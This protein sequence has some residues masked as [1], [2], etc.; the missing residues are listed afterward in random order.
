[1]RQ[2][3][4]AISENSRFLFAPFSVQLSNRQDVSFR[5]VIASAHI[6]VRQNGVIVQGGSSVVDPF[7]GTAS[8]NNFKLST[9][10]NLESITYDVVSNGVICSSS[11]GLPSLLQGVQASILGSSIAIATVPSAV[12]V[13]SLP[14]TRVVFVGVSSLSV[15]FLVLDANQAQLFGVVVQIMVSLVFLFMILFLFFSQIF[16]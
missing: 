15:D 14:P 1:M 10:L 8:F 9:A 2:P 7:T 6:V 13:T 5:V 12:F 16:Q 4:S 3:T 11:S